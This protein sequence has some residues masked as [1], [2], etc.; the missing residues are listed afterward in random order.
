MSLKNCIKTKNTPQLPTDFFAAEINWVTTAT[1]EMADPSANVSF[2]P[3][4][5]TT[6]RHVKWL[7][8][9]Y[10]WC[11][12]WSIKHKKGVLRRIMVHMVVHF[13]VLL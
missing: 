9:Q 11:K 8:R 13:A 10:R 2:I 3:M 5:R 6:G 1:M 4:L 12:M 7:S